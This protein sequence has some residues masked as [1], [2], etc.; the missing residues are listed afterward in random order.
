MEQGK[1]GERR[2][3]GRRKGEA[4]RERVGE[5]LGEIGKERRGEWKR[6]KLRGYL[7]VEQLTWVSEVSRSSTRSSIVKDVPRVVGT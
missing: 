4:G 1:N 6:E 3:N 2:E 7:L 5:G